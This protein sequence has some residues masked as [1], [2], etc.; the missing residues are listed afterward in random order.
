M[1]LGIEEEVA[2]LEVPMDEFAGVHVLEGLEELVDDE[3]FVNFL[4][5]AGANDNVQIWDKFQKY[6]S[7]CSRILSRDPC[8]FRLLLCSA[9]V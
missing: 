2:G 1:A 3:L 4:E 9:T 7:T 5:D 8:Y 6:R